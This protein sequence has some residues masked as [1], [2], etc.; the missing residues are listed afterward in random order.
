[1]ASTTQLRA[2]AVVTAKTVIHMAD[3]HVL[4]GPTRRREF[5]F[6]QRRGIQSGEGLT[7][8]DIRRPPTSA[9]REARGRTGTGGSVCRVPQQRGAML[10]GLADPA[11]GAARPSRSPEWRMTRLGFIGCSDGQRRRDCSVHAVPAFQRRPCSLQRGFSVV[12][13]DSVPAPMP[14][15]SGGSRPP[16][17]KPD[18]RRK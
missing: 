15:A 8:A 14:R 9:P 3:L 18:G 12:D 4:E 6:V 16:L 10:S 13:V 17:P 2:I 5:G 11:A 1:M 7:A